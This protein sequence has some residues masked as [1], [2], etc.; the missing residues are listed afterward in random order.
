M[1]NLFEKLIAAG[2]GKRKLNDPLFRKD[3]PP[4]KYGVFDLEEEHISNQTVISTCSIPGCSF[5][6]DSVLDFENH[7]NSAHRYSCCQCKK[8]LPSPHLLDLHIQENHDSYFAVL[9][10][11]R[12]SYCCYIEACKEKFMTPDERLS[13]C[14]KLHKIPKDFRFDQ[15]PKAKI[16]N[17]T[18]KMDVDNKKDQK[19]FQLKNSKQISFKNTGK[20]FPPNSNKETYVNID[21]V[22][23]ELKD[24]LPE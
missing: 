4:P 15:K 20:K 17:Q 18:N 23:S 3:E 21:Q 1:Q 10:T 5:T 7:Y 2:V 19:P 9:A 6:T 14:V 22:M 12:A 24:N 8:V 13:H 11:K 16:K